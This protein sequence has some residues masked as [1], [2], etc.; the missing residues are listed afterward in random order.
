MERKDI[1][2]AVSESDALEVIR[3]LLAHSQQFTAMIEELPQRKIYSSYNHHL[4][5]FHTANQAATRALI[6][7]EKAIQTYLHDYQ[8]SKDIHTHMRE[9]LSRMRD[10]AQQRHNTR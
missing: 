3:Q 5:E 9:A 6:A 1:Y 7:Y 8:E 10:E 4:D 2:A